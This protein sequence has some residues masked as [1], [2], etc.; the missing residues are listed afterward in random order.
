MMTLVE[1]ALS[2]QA[3]VPQGD[4]VAGLI[5]GPFAD[6][7]AAEYGITVEVAADLPLAAV[8]AA[9]SAQTPV[10]AQH[11]DTGRQDARRHLQAGERATRQNRPRSRTAFGHLHS[12]SLS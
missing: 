4:R 2:W 6:W 12:S 10:I 8:T 7:V 11:A 1:G 3:Y 9:A 5:Y